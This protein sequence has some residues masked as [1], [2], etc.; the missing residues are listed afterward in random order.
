MSMTYADAADRRVAEAPADG[1]G[2]FVPRYA[3]RRKSRKPVKTWMILAPIG[4][5]AVVGTA[6]ALIMGGEQTEAPVGPAP[7]SSAQ[8]QTAPGALQAADSQAV[9]MPS[10]VDAPAAQPVQAEPVAVPRRAEAA[11][12][13]VAPAQTESRPQPTMAEA[14]P[15]G[16]RPYSAEATTALNAA[17]A[18]PAQAPISVRVPSTPTVSV[19]PVN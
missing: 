10:V 15:E 6:A 5:L 12:R 7:V 13:R 11:P 2:V 16:P 17:P 1:S 19:Q 18:A 3:Q 9:V 4:A 8:M 14:E